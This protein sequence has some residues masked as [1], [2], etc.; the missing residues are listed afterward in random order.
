MIQET[1]IETEDTVYFF[2]TAYSAFHDPFA[3]SWYGE[4]HNGPHPLSRV[5]D[6]IVD[7][8]L[9]HVSPSST[10]WLVTHG[11]DNVCVCGNDD[12]SEW[13]AQCR[14]CNEDSV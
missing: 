9:N 6:E 14:A 2:N 3:A 12:D 11:P 1:P 10:H 8:F 5:F 4:R 7:Y 13:R